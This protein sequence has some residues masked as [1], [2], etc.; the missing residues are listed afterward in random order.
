MNGL[1]V[2]CF[3]KPEFSIPQI[4]E[5]GM[6]LSRWRPMPA[7]RMIGGHRCYVWL[8]AYFRNFRSSFMNLV[9][10]V[11][12]WKDLFLEAARCLSD[13]LPNRFTV[14]QANHALGNIIIAYITNFLSLNHRRRIHSSWIGNNRGKKKGAFCFRVIGTVTSPWSVKV[15][16]RSCLHNMHLISHTWIWTASLNFSG[17]RWV[18]YTHIVIVFFFSLQ[19]QWVKRLSWNPNASIWNLRSWSHPF[20]RTNTRLS[21]HK[22]QLEAKTEGIARK[23]LDLDK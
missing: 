8:N 9:N 2:I 5:I 10:N 21:I 13:Q 15:L 16:C 23:N 22:A 12:G 1:I 14:F 18:F 7:K 17:Y 11:G 4:V 6:I 3:K 20:L 19:D